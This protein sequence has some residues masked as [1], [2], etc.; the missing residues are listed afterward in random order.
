MKNK[1]FIW[2][3][4][5]FAALIFASCGSGETKTEENATTD[6]AAKAPKELTDL[7][8]VTSYYECP[9]KCE[10]KKFSEAG[11]CPVCG[12]E[13]ALIEVKADSIPAPAD[14]THQM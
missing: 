7:A 1:N 12:M 6:A 13:L 10:G 5:L 11:A 3:L 8:G 14:T 4:M 9:M 2:P